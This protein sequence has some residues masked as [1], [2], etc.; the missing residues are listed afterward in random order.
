MNIVAAKTTEKSFLQN[1][2][3]LK[4]YDFEPYNLELFYRTDSLKHKKSEELI[5]K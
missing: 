2:C 1:H 3:F 5:N 4:P